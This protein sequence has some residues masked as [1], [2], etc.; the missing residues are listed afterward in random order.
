MITQEVW[1]DLRA[2]ARHGTLSPARPGPV[3]PAAA[4]LPLE[5]MGPQAVPGAANARCGPAVGL[6]YGDNRAF[7]NGLIT[8]RGPV[9]AGRCY[10]LTCSGLIDM[11]H[12]YSRCEH[13]VVGVTWVLRLLPC[14]PGTTHR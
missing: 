5:A 12:R 7:G 6:E 8:G 1:M 14:L 2:L 9:I 3:E 13:Q 11:Q 10:V 4:E